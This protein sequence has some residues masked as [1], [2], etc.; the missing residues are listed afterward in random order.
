MSQI[1]N[2]EGEIM[3]DILKAFYPVHYN[4]AAL[5]L[6]M[7]LLI[8][9]LLTKKNYKWSIIIFVIL[10]V[11]NMFIYTRTNHKSWTL[12]PEAYTDSYGMT[13]MGQPMTFKPDSNWVNKKGIVFGEDTIHHWCWVDQKWAEFA[14]M[15]LVAKIWGENSSKKM[16]KASE[17]HA[18]FYFIIN[19]LTLTHHL[20][21]ED[22]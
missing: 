5:S 19:F 18:N 10:F 21:I 3:I 8:I 13:R 17:N 14:S 20:L 1:K 11:F 12:T 7:L 6:L 22:R 4:F 15:D 9:Y 2:K 16:I